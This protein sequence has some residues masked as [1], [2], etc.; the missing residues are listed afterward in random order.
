MNDYEYT[1]IQLTENSEGCR[2]TPYKDG[3]GVWT[4]GFGNTWNVNPE[5]TI[6][7]DQ[8]IA[9]LKTNLAS[10]EETVKNDVKVELTQGEYNAL[11]DFVFNL[12]SGNFAGSTL[13]KKINAGDYKNAALEFPRWDLCAGEV[14]QGLLNRRLAEQAEFDQQGA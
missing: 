13:L 6:T 7:M 2:L 9:D 5:V 1:G 10:A 14:S 8:A 4:N 3:A 11:V 12:G